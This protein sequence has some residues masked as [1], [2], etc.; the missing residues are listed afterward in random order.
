MWE[1]CYNLTTTQ[2]VDLPADMKKVAEKP[3]KG[4]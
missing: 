2:V 4:E 3:Q 1:F